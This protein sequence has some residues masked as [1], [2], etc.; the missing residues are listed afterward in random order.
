MPVARRL[1][2]CCWLQG[3]VRRNRHAVS[4]ATGFRWDYKLLQSLGMMVLFF[5]SLGNT[6]GQL[7]SET[8]RRLLDRPDVIVWPSAIGVFQP[9]SFRELE[10]S[11]YVRKGRRSRRRESRR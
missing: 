1:L 4:T 2:R 5:S 6:K 11:H 9:N 8:A 3:F 10:S 7:D